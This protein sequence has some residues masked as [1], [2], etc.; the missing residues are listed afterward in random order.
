MTDPETLATLPARELVS[1]AA[2]VAKYGLFR[3]GELL[4][5]CEALA[6]AGLS[7]QA[8]DTEL[9][10]GCVQAKLDVVA[11]DEREETGVRAVLNLGHT[12]GHAIEAAG[13]FRRF[14]HG[15]AVA[16]GLRAALWLSQRRQR[17]RRRT[18]P[19][20]ACACW[21]AWA[22]RG[23][24]RASRRSRCATSC[25]ATRRP[26]PQGV[27]YVLLEALGAPVTGCRRDAAARA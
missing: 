7:A 8:V 19:S 1:G 5:R 10:A 23:A 12:L 20:A 25:A 27:G 14:T 4:A 22:C 3:G 9:L 18:R 13:R 11:A 15:E 6:A 21:T 2:E 17:P 26:A 24:C 16:L